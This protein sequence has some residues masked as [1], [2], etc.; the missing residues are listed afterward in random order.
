ML[1]TPVGAGFIETMARPGGNATG[2]V[3]F[4]Y[5]LSGKWLEL[6]KQ[7]VPQ[8]TRVAV[9]RDAAIA[10]GIGQFAIIEAAA[11]PLGVEVSAINL[12]DAAVIERD[13]T[14][15]ASAPNGGLILTASAL[16][17][18]HGEQVVALAAKY[19]LPAV[20]YRSYF[21]DVGGLVSYGYDVLQ[22]YRSVAS[23]T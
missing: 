18:V 11:T 19:K 23:H 12:S 16:S 1:Q 4:E 22:Q 9:L 15:F 8:L 2:F 6:L 10:S 3:Q 17:I 13:I 7:I 14:A 5:S 20:Y 21:V